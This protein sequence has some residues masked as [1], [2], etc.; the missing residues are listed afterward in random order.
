MIDSKLTG[1]GVALVT[2]FT[3][4]GNIDFQSLKELVE[5]VIS[6]EIDY[7]VALGT[8][9][10]TPT[11]SDSEKEEVVKA[12]IQTNDGR[13]PIV[14]GIGGP[15]TDSIVNKLKNFDFHGIDAILSVTPYYNKPSQK[16]LYQ[17]YSEIS[18]YSPLP[19]IIY[20]VPSRTSCNIDATTT[21]SLAEECKNIIAIKEASGNMNQ[22]MTIINHKP[23]SFAV[24]SGDDAITLPLLAA[25]GDGVI[26][27]IGNAFPHDFAQL[28]KA[29]QE[30][31]YEDALKIHLRLFDLIQACFKEG[32]PSGVKAVL[33]EQ[34][35]IQNIL[36]LP[37]TPV[38]E[39]LYSHI[40]HL[41][42]IYQKH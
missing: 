31:R 15:S 34:S 14:M 35:K 20:N 7:I 41:L 19:I 2:P 13:I 6:N 18:Y 38:S 25:G 12:I 42:N 40:Q 28:Y 11:L 36:R 1:V 4:D 27:V 23:D 21:L 10:E 16:G 32:N 22:I 24:I 39:E 37:L 17:H 29:T 26:S 3:D 33:H 5:N 8:T 9:S 30:N